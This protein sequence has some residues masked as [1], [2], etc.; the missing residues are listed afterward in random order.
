VIFE[1]A[2]AQS[3]LQN[4]QR[5]DEHVALVFE[6][7]EI[8]LSAQHSPAVFA[9]AKSA[10]AANAGSRAASFRAFARTAGRFRRRTRQALSM[11]GDERVTSWRDGCGSTTPST[12]RDAVVFRIRRRSL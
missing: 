6:H 9:I 11:R 7:L 10:P 4:T 12:A 8:I 2:L 5:L 1:A 3:A